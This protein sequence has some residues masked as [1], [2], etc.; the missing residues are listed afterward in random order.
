MSEI[1]SPGYI[2]CFTNTYMPGICKVG[3][4][5]RSPLERLK[6][7]NSDTWSPPVWKCEFAK[8]VRDCNRKE[9]S[10]HRVLEDMSEHIPRREMFKISV[11]KV[12]RVFDL[13]DGDYSSMDPLPISE[14]RIQLSEPTIQTPKK[15]V[16]NNA[17]CRNQ[18]KC[19]EDGQSIRHTIGEDRW[20]A[21]YRKS[22]NTI[23]HENVGYKSLTEFVSKHYEKNGVSPS[24]IKA[25]QE[26]E[27]FLK[28][29]WISTYNLSAT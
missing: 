23:E 24:T 15:K 28:E 11:D 22:S 10:I 17:G 16:L 20:Q 3:K 26:C 14:E 5:E 19:F 1:D 27:C 7:A 29:R 18:K 6:E 9:Q 8:Y 25:W 4:T 21:V 2:Y 13:L 12:R